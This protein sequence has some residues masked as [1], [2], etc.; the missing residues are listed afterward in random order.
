M[1]ES[2]TLWEYYH[3]NDAWD[4]VLRAW[5]LNALKTPHAKT[6]FV[7]PSIAAIQS[8]KRR[9]LEDNI[10]VVGIHF[11]A[12]GQARNYLKKQL[13]LNAPLALREDLLLCL[14]LAAISLPP[15]PFINSILQETDSALKLWD[16]LS[17]AGSTASE[18]PPS[19]LTQILNQANKL[20]EAVGLN[21]TQSFDRNLLSQK[22]PVIDNLCI[23]G[24]TWRHWNRFN[25]LLSSVN[26]A[27]DSLLC[28]PAVESTTQAAQS[29]KESWETQASP[30]QPIPEANNHNMPFASLALQAEFPDNTFIDTSID[31]KDAFPAI[32]LCQNITQEADLIYQTT[33]KHLAE[34]S[35]AHIG[36]IFPSEGSSLARE[37]AFRFEKNNIPHL[38]NFGYENRSDPAE[39]L[40]INWCQFQQSRELIDWVTFLDSLALFNSKF[41]DSTSQLKQLLLNAFRETL[42]DDTLIILAYINQKTLST[43]VTQLLQT[44]TLLPEYIEATGFQ[45]TITQLHQLGWDSLE[46]NT[47]LNFEKFLTYKLTG[48]HKAF[49]IDWLKNILLPPKKTSHSCGKQIYSKI[50][51]I[52]VQE[53]Y[54]Q[55][56]THLIFAEMDQSSWPPITQENRLFPETEAHAINLSN[57]QSPE[58]L[59][60]NKMHQWLLSD[61]D[62]KVYLKF[63]FFNLIKKVT[64]SLTF[65]FSSLSSNNKNQLPSE[66]LLPFI[67]HAEAR[68][69]NEHKK[70]IPIQLEQEPEPLAQEL[71]S[72][73]QSHLTIYNTRRDS[74]I[75]FDHYSF[76]LKEPHSSFL[77][78]PCKAWEDIIKTPG[79]AWYK[80]V[81]KLS[82]WS[83][84]FEKDVSTLAQGNWVHDW[85]ALDNKNASQLSAINLTAL[86]NKKAHALKNKIQ[87]LYNSCEKP[88]PINWLATFII[89]QET[90]IAFANVIQKQ[91]LWQYTWSEITLPE[92]VNNRKLF[93]LSLRGRIDS[94]GANTQS[95]NNPFEL[96]KTDSVWII[97]YKTGSMP[98]FNATNITRGYGLQLAL[99]GLAIRQL[100]FQ[101]IQ[102]T[103]LK[104]DAL[105][106]EIFSFTE[107]LESNESFLHGLSAIKEK[108]ILGNK[109][110]LRSEYGFTGNF[111][112]ATLSIPESILQ[113]KWALSHP[114]LQAEETYDAD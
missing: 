109:G 26:M 42:T 15:A 83:Q 84:D 22:H 38:N 89:A 76:S 18:N 58:S 45:T 105:K 31:P 80:H 65:T 46:N 30:F 8:I 88:L 106:P 57:L 51:L 16:D 101:N 14:R 113:S 66:L 64:E 97:D 79:A 29:W 27:Q 100:G 33:L 69:L 114:Q 71:A 19:T 44:F 2:A 20:L 108:G 36:I 11:L 94:I 50:E 81:L 96:N 56:W 52:S 43:E 23:F 60:L 86:V 41:L 32:Y 48:I 70:L 93:K 99:Y 4:K 54:L 73:L 104:K 3:V 25:L 91:D 75:P 107:F 78:I 10:P 61:N 9:L 90:A 21:T 59:S 102:L 112:L 55:N 110:S 7:A 87:E 17:T 39:L 28:F 5:F 98:A 13:T 24:F 63:C 47:K 82:P 95:N 111:P 35:N 103:L 92:S 49:F 37:I 6:V 53:A 40:L 62:Q 12:P 68:Y 1:A 85:L 74:S 34:N 72:E 67:P 77:E